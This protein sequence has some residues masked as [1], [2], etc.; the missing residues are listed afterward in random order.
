MDLTNMTREISPKKVQKDAE[1][2]FRG[3]Y[4]CSEAVMDAVRK[5]FGLNVSDDVIAMASGMAVGAGRSGCMCGALN[6]GI[7]ALSLFFGRTEPNGPK[8]PKVNKC[9]ELT[10]ELHD[11]FKENNGKKAVCYRAI[12]RESGMY[13]ELWR[14]FYWC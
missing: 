3:G 7:L 2:A 8:D 9:M 13:V 5:N 1:E 14:H 12:R 4:F 10:H 6:G 11:W